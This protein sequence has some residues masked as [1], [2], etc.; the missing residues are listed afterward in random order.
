[1]EVTREATLAISELS[2]ASQMRNLIAQQRELAELEQE[3]QDQLKTV[4][5]QLHSLIAVVNDSAERASLLKLKRNAKLTDK[6]VDTAS[7]LVSDS[8]SELGSNLCRLKGVILKL[9]EERAR[10]RALFEAEKEQTKNELLSLANLPNV[11]HGIKY[12]APGL[13]TK[14]LEITRNIEADDKAAVS[15]KDLS[16]VFDFLFRTAVKTTPISSFTIITVHEMIDQKPE[17]CEAGAVGTTNLYSTLD[18]RIVS[19]L[20][21]RVLNEPQVLSSLNFRI[22]STFTPLNDTSAILIAPPP[23]N[24]IVQLSDPRLLDLTLKLGNRDW[25]YT[26]TLALLEDY[27]GHEGLNTLKYLIASGILEVVAPFDRVSPGIISRLAAFI[28][29]FCEKYGTSKMLSDA[30][31]ESNNAVGFDD[32]DQ[33]LNFPTLLR[34]LKELDQIEKEKPMP[35]STL[36]KLP[37]MAGLQARVRDLVSTVGIRPDIV[38]GREH[39]LHEITIKSERSGEALG[40]YSQHELQELRTCFSEINEWLSIFEPNIGTR[41]A[42]ADYIEMELGRDV[43][44]PLVEFYSML[45]KR[46][47][48]D[49]DESLLLWLGDTPVEIETLPSSV[50]T[51]RLM[52]LKRERENSKQ[53]V[54]RRT[55]SAESQRCEISREDIVNQLI[56]RPIFLVNGSR[57]ITYWQET[58]AG[59]V[60]NSVHVGYRRGIDRLTSLTRK[61]SK[62]SRASEGDSSKEK[63]SEQRGLL[64]V[65]VAQRDIQV[66]TWGASFGSSLNWARRIPD[67]L[68][69]YPGYESAALKGATEIRDLAV[70]FS[71]EDGLLELF[72]KSNGKPVRIEHLGMMANFQLPPLANFLERVFARP[73][74]FHPSKGPFHPLIN[75]KSDREVVNVPRI[76]ID[77]V[78]IQR[79]RKII[80]CELMPKPP[81]DD[82]EYWLW[83]RSLLSTHQ[84]DPQTFVRCWT[85]PP[86]KGNPK[87]RKPFFLDS[88]SWWSVREFRRRSQGAT[89]LV[90]D[91]CLP[92]FTN[93]AE[94]Y[95]LREYVTESHGW[96]KAT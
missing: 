32:G 72:K 57:A 17:T 52:Q 91:E 3:A 31:L 4:V 11:S 16:H 34:V 75:L 79:C 13:Y 24:A 88:H 84:L 40:G 43:E 23:S 21:S 50:L 51:P 2:T 76:S 82:F 42:L 39:P 65:T 6:W 36:Q 55:S 45:M 5:D 12:S 67:Q 66:L 29:E 33:Y 80:P 28:E 71:K 54:E 1:M 86:S 69:R 14:L 22:N 37:D 8:H 25:S 41:L 73:H 90:F 47:N 83:L 38:L 63:E 70:R 96:R 30:A 58:S 48:N 77:G 95:K 94:G 92:E 15:D 7:G 19:A 61:P 53:L 93:L 81:S 9:R 87:A 64:S 60:I 62:G 18:G 49:K 68:V 46:R 10:S 27:L 59:K 20:E 35:L 56:E 44:M 74:L 85:Y 26:E 78:T 89:F